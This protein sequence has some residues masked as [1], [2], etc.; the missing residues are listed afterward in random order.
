MY[1]YDRSVDF[2]SY[3]TYNFIE[4][5]GPDTGD[6]QSFFYAVHDR[7]DHDRNGNTRLYE[8]S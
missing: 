6:Y 3:Q 5:V 4:G 1:D 7:C 2:G 8:I